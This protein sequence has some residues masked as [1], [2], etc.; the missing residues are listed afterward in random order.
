MTEPAPPAWPILLRRHL[1]QANKLC[2]H[3]VARI[4][5]GGMVGAALAFSYATAKMKEVDRAMLAIMQDGMA[6]IQM[7]EYREI[8]AIEV[9]VRDK[10]D[11]ATIIQQ[12]LAGERVSFSTID[13]ARAYLL[14]NG[15]HLT[16]S[17]TDPSTG[18]VTH[19]DIPL[20]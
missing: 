17:T 9:A 2:S 8:A 16:R 1:T 20:R 18:G 19:S 5:F 12:A 11:M 6:A 4:L 13:D 7:R 14:A 3:P 15:Q 10:P